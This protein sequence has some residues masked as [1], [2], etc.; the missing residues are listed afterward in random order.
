MGDKTRHT[1]LS[2]RILASSSPSITSPILSSHAKSI[3]NV[4]VAFNSINLVLMYLTVLSLRF[5]HLGRIDRN[6]STQEY[7]RSLIATA[8]SRS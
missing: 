5:T 8:V 2:I 4:P 3:M 7:F 1:S 6:V